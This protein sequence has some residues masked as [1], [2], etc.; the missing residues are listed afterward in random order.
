M[1]V[2]TEVLQ[3]GQVGTLALPAPELCDLGASSQR[4]QDS[5]SSFAK[6]GIQSCLQQGPRGG[7]TRDPGGRPV[8]HPA[9]S[10][11]LVSYMGTWHRAAWDQALPPTSCVASGKSPTLSEPQLPPY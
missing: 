8:Q 3:S 9:Q 1:G 5:D 10:Q 11:C 6:W 2:K 4:P 7:V